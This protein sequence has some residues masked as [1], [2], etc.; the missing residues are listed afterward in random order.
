[1]STPPSAPI[2]SAFQGFT[3]SPMGSPSPTPTMT[4]FDPSLDFLNKAREQYAESTLLHDTP[5]SQLSQTSGSESDVISQHSNLDPELYSASSHVRRAPSHFGALLKARFQLT[6]ESEG[7]LDRYIVGQ[8]L[9]F[10]CQL[11]C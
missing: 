3:P 9:N 5:L 10:S 6:G 11:P 1:M 4:P 2:G 7:D 8:F